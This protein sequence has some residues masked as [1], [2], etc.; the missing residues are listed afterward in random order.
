MKY[1][2]FKY[3]S[4]QNG[5]AHIYTMDNGIEF[6]EWFDGKLYAYSGSKLLPH[7]ETLK[8]KQA[9][10]VQNRQKLEMASIE[11]D[12]AIERNT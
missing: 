7:A 1:T 10:W 11:Q 2:E 6:V 9:I 4:D 12:L 8:I 5:K 3:H